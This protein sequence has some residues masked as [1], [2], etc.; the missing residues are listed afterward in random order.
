MS[1]YYKKIHG[2]SYDRAMLDIAEGSVAGKGDGRISLADARSIVKQVN[3]SGKITDIERRT[4]NYILENFQM[5]ETALKHIEKSVSAGIEPEIKKGKKVEPAETV[6]REMRPV[7]EPAAKSGWKK[8]FVTI[9]LLLLVLLL[10]LYAIFRFFY[11]PRQAVNENLASGKQGESTVAGDEALVSGTDKTAVGGDT[12]VAGTAMKTE[13]PEVKQV[14]KSLAENEY[15]VKD[16]DTLIRISETVY[17]DYRKWKE[18]YRLNK[19]KI[20]NPTILYPGQVL[21]LPEKN[22]EKK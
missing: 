1:S 4:L 9:F 18:I 19:G 13:Q 3:D 11:K 2:K 14:V 20:A 5:T 6:S 16:Q 15:L 17:G 7:E 10:A 22:S 12:T 8:K 21:V